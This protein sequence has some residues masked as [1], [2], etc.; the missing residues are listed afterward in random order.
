[1]KQETIEK[2]INYFEENEGSFES[3][4]ED[5]DAYNGYLDDCRCYP[6]MDL[7]EILYGVEPSE[8]L[9]MAHFGNFNWNDNYFSFNAY[10]NLESCYEKDYSFLLDKWFVESYVEYIT[11]YGFDFAD[12]EIAEILKEDI[13][14][15]A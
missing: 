14:E 12:D 8:I 2:I 15:V 5:L 13:Q 11:D 4:I 1:M 10:G 3:A 7:D 9:R 6:M